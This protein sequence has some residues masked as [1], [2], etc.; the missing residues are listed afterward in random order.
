MVNPEFLDGSR[1]VCGIVAFTER[2]TAPFFVKKKKK[3]KNKKTFHWN[4]VSGDVTSRDLSELQC[5][6]RA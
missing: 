2:N 4:Q 1:S 6:F 3:T 5:R